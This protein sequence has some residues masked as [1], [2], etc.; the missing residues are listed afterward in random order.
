MEVSNDEIRIVNKDV[1][2]RGGHEDAGQ[3]ADDEHCHERQR[4]QHRRGELNVT[5]PDGAQPVER[6]NG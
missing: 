5:A 4:E 6:L 3:T 2:R 1:H